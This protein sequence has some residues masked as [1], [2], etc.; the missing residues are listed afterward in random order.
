MQWINNQSMIKKLLL[1]LALP[2]AAMLFFAISSVLNAQ[3]KVNS[4]QMVEKFVALSETVSGL[5]H[6]LQ[7]ERGMSA[8]FLGSHGKKFVDKLPQQRQSADEELQKVKKEIEHLSARHEDGKAFDIPILDNALDKV[9]GDL[10]RLSTIR[11]NIDSFEIP[12]KNELAYYTGIISVLHNMNSDLAKVLA[13]PADFHASNLRANADIAMMMLVYHQ[14]SAVKEA[15]GIERAVLSNAFA[16]DKFS[17]AMYDKFV[18]L[19]ARE[20]NAES[21]FLSIAKPPM[22]K[23]YHTAMQGDAIDRVNHFRDLAHQGQQHGKMDVNAEEWFAAASARI[24]LL[25]SLEITDLKNITADADD[26]TSATVTRRNEIGATSVIL[27]LLILAA[28]AFITLNISGRTRKILTIIETIADGKLDQ[29]I[30]N[31]AHDELGQVIDGLEKMRTDL[32]EAVAMRERLAAEEQEAMQHKEAVRQREAEVVHDFEG[33][34]T[35]LSESFEGVTGSVAEGSQLVAAAA[36]ESSRQAEVSANEAHQV[37]GNVSTVAAAAEELSASINEVSR[38]VGE[39]QKIV[40][41]AVTEAESTTS[42]VK[43][44]SEATAEISQVIEI[45]TNIAGQTNMLA[46]N[47]SIEAARAGDAG[48]GFAVVAG[49]VKELASQTAKATEKIAEQI[50]RLQAESEHS[51]EAISNIAEIIQQVGAITSTIN[52]AADEQA[53]AANEISASV[54]NA[55]A[56]VNDMTVSITDVSSAAN[57]TGKAASSMLASS[58]QLVENTA[59]LNEHVQQFLTGLQQIEESAGQ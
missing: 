53:T 57:D 19:L 6:E 34:I 5:V 14:L 18:T 8:G 12:L 3:H 39:A 58:Q 11:N 20:Q 51:A 40:S 47:A 25:R 2:L 29:P 49:E 13:N 17:P 33:K 1:L 38:Q 30:I 43:N 56:R 46:L 31:H 24:K 50:Q 54:Q 45:I 52:A 16:A 55:S 22:V 15:S 42:T 7:G 41:Q 48:R 23:A 27:L 37:E 4:L 9:M 21:L 26:A 28:A 44:L 32:A 10:E 35:A 59:Q 36:E